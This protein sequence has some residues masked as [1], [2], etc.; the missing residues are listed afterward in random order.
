MLEDKD[1]LVR[2]SREGFEF[3]K[4]LSQRKSERAARAIPA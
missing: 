2:R 4:N 1:V 3:F